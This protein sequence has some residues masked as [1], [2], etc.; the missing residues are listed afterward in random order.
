M[1]EK[2]KKKVSESEV[3]DMVRH[4]HRT[5]R[6]ERAHQLKGLHK[7]GKPIPYEL[8][9]TVGVKSEKP[10]E[11]KLEMP[12]RN[13]KTADWQAFAAQVSDFDGSVLK[14]MGRDEIIEILEQREIIPTM[15]E[16]AEQEAA[17]KAEA[18]AAEET[19]EEEENE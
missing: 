1:T 5:G 2:T 7:A 6:P 16:Q 18:E 15:E 4:W 11:G 9:D 17:E 19:E 3:A 12:A 13:V 8:L 14:K 10:V